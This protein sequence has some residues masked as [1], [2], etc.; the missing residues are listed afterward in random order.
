MLLF[1]LISRLIELC[2]FGYLDRSIHF[3]MRV[4]NLDS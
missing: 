2:L 4:L 1:N 3:S